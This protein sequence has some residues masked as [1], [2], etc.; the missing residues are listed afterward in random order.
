MN[1]PDLLKEV[2]ALLSIIK[3]SHKGSIGTPNNVYLPT[4]PVKVVNRLSAQVAS[5]ILSTT[6]P[7]ADDPPQSPQDTQALAPPPK[8]KP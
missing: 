8:G 4:L 3:R 7:N 6:A 2:H 1:I 5:M